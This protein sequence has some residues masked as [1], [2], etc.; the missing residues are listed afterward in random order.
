MCGSKLLA[1]D[2]VEVR[3]LVQPRGTPSGS[4][5]SQAMAL[6]DAMSK[7]G[8]EVV[9]LQAWQRLRGGM[10]AVRGLVVRE[11]YTFMASHPK[12]LPEAAPH[13]MLAALGIPPRR[14]KGHD[15]CAW[16]GFAVRGRATGGAF[17]ARFEEALRGCIASLCGSVG[18]AAF[19]GGGDAFLS[20]FLADS[21]VLCQRRQGAL[22]KV[23]V[24]EGGAMCSSSAH[25]PFTRNSSADVNV[26]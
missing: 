15:A 24:G 1:W 6:A 17:S 4:F 12:A 20:A 9:F 14:V 10:G 16:G 7:S 19:A 25:A 22:E 5:T 8:G 2:K 3:R 13:E 11:G 26:G 23:F 18:D 21:H